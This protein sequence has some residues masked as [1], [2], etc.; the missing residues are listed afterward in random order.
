MNGAVGCDATGRPQGTQSAR[1]ATD[2]GRKP[3]KA[4]RA[5]YRCFKRGSADD[6]R[7]NK[8]GGR[9]EARRDNHSIHRVERASVRSLARAGRAMLAK[10]LEA[11]RRTATPDI[12]TGSHPLARGPRPADSPCLPA[13]EHKVTRGPL[14][15]RAGPPHTCHAAAQSAA[16]FGSP[17]REAHMRPSADAGAFFVPASFGPIRSPVQR[18]A[19]RGSRKARRSSRRSSNRAPSVTPFGSGL[20]VTPLR[21][22]RHHE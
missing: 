19:V 22:D 21:E 9:L 14:D 3:L 1:S 7:Q 15:A 11:R 18:R 5:F 2:T 13:S 16:G 4:W 10:R 6:C 17:C 20:T 8:D 12:G